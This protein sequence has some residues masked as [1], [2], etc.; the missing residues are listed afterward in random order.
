MAFLHKY[1]MDLEYIR[2]VNHLIEHG[3]NNKDQIECEAYKLQINLNDYKLPILTIRERDYSM[4]NSILDKVNENQ[5]NVLVKYTNNDMDRCFDHVVDELKKG[6]D[7]TISNNEVTCTFKIK[8]E[9]LTCILYQVECDLNI[10]LPQNITFYSMLT[11]ILSEKCN[12]KPDKLIYSVG[13]IYTSSLDLSKLE[14]EMT[15][16]IHEPPTLI[17]KNG[18]LEY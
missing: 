15:N 14:K 9:H 3:E 17:N 4:V 18:K 11:Y 5:S 13:T 10:S 2:L 12:L 16:F 6:N 7:T 8:N 1:N